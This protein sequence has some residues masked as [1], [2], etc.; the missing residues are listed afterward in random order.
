MEINNRDNFSQNDHIDFS[1]IKR[2]ILRS[3]YLILIATIIA[4]FFAFF[5]FPN[6]KENSSTGEYKIY[7]NNRILLP[8]KFKENIKAG[9][10]FLTSK[11][12]SNKV[13]DKLIEKMYSDSFY[14]NLFLKY[15]RD[16][17]KIEDINLAY[18][19]SYPEIEYLTRGISKVKFTSIGE[20]TAI[21]LDNYI[22]FI[23]FYLNNQNYKCFERIIGQYN[24]SLDTN[25][26]NIDPKLKNVLKEYINYLEFEKNNFFEYISISNKFIELNDKENAIYPLIVLLTISYFILFII[27][28]LKENFFGNI[29]EKNMLREKL[30][31]N[32]LDTIYK[33]KTEKCTVEI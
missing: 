29:Y 11:E 18:L 5:V 25:L 33:N 20:Y 1:L 17:K 6:L 27:I 16:N 28:I 9:P 31:I 12:C 26:I 21:V 24:N 10:Q 30:I 19:N 23:N 13:T 22:E 14:Q 4:P 2:I 32:Y 8:D 3:K 15:M 7:L